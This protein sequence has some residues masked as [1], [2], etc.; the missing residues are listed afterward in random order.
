VI[1]LIAMAALTAW[2][3]SC[4]VNLA[5]AVLGLPLSARAAVTLILSFQAGRVAFAWWVSRHG[6]RQ[7]RALK[8]PKLKL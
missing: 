2:V 8:G 7:K 6:N 3:S 4:S 5:G 1:R